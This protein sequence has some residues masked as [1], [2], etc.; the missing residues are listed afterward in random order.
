MRTSFHLGLLAIVLG[1]GSVAACAAEV[2]SLFA[3]GGTTGGNGGAGGVGGAGGQ[4]GL[5]GAGGQGGLGGAGGQGGAASNSS[6]AA[7]GT[8][9]SSSS[10]SGTGGQGGGGFDPQVCGQCAYGACQAEIFACGQ[11]CAG[12]IS[13]AQNCTDKL[14]VDDCLTQYPQAQP[15]Y[16]CT[17]GSCSAQC[18]SYCDGASTSSSSTTTSSSASGTGGGGSACSTCSEILQ[19]GGNDPPCQGSDVLLS[20]FFNCTC[21]QNCTTE[22]ASSCQGGQPSQACF[23][24]VQQKCGQQLNA[25]LQ[26]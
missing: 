24:C 14:C 2:E 20:E 12:F 11:T 16:D 8:G 5:G 10:A 18:G 15:V 21:Q 22:C 19:G 13:C 6:S 25:C 7:T 9:P 23:G 4:G 17:C 26:D 3:S 1:L